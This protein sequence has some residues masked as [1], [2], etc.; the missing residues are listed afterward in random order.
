MDVQ[1]TI[2][3]WFII[4][5]M[6]IPTTCV[7][8]G[9]IPKTSQQNT[10]VYKGMS[11]WYY[12]QMHLSMPLGTCDIL[13]NKTWVSTQPISIPL[14]LTNLVNNIKIVPLKDKCPFC[15]LSYEL[16]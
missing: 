15:Q 14:N 5:I 3:L 13:L 9:Y 11:F 10:H 12:L 1:N 7:A 6:K 2:S 8:L 4:V 16:I